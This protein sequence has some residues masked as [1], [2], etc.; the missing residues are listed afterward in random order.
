MK[1]FL[2]VLAVLII[3]LLAPLLLRD[4]P[5]PTHTGTLPWQV[6]L[7]ADGHSR[8][9]GITLDG[10]TLADVRTTVNADLLLAVVATGNE[11]GALE[12]YI[13]AFNAGPVTGRLFV[14]LDASADTLAGF[15]QRSPKSEYMATGAAKKYALSAADT[16]LAQQLPVRALSFIPSANLDADVVLERFG[17]P[18]E[19]VRTT[20]HTEHFLYPA[21]G[22]DVIVDSEGKELLQYVS[23]ARFEQL[24]APLVAAA[25]TAT[26]SA[27][28]PTKP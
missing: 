23:P 25:S 6:D 2:A 19:R 10:S 28:T 11:T 15:K 7:L 13:E 20:P 5:P 24:R 14:T 3:A 4:T 16:E 1:M 27:T 12:A 21:K 9:F 17:T 18:A 8:V 22:L 26:T